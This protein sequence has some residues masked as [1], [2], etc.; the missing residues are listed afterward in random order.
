MLFGDSK[1][2]LCMVNLFQDLI[3]NTGY[4]SRT[5]NNDKS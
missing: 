4:K 5:A 2:N 1:D 3:L